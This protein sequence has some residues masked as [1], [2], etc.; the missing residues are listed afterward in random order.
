MKKLDHEF[1]IAEY[2]LTHFNTMF[3]FRTPC[4]RQKTFGFLTFS[5]EIEMEH[6]ANKELI[7]KLLMKKEEVFNLS[8]WQ[9]LVK[10]VIFAAVLIPNVRLINS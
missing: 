2:S 3:Y 10:S 7:N 8:T 1:K 9:D 4:K 5:G 6:W